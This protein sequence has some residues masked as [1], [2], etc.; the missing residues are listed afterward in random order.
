MRLLSTLLLG[1]LIGTVSEAQTDPGKSLIGK[2]EGEV[3][4]AGAGG[5]R[6][7]TLIIQSVG[8]KDGKLVAEGRYGVTGK[9]LGKVQIEVST[10]GKWP[11]IRFVT[12][13]NSTVRLDLIDE[14]SMTG[15]MT[16]AG[17]SQHGSDRAMNLKRVD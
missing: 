1:L 9:G 2:W 3:Q 13:A 7:R 15:K 8:E 5:D 10:S 12:G 6:N 17:A 14:K 16:L 11:S 4:L